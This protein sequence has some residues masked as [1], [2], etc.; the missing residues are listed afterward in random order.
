MQEPGPAADDVTAARRIEAKGH[1][2]QGYEVTDADFDV[3]SM[4]VE[5]A[6][7]AL[8][9]RQ[10]GVIVARLRAPKLRKHT[11]FWEPENEHDTRVGD[12]PI[13]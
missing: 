9:A 5:A 8:L 10:E 11:R 6:L 7:T 4:A 3:L 13:D 1:P 2:Q 12:A